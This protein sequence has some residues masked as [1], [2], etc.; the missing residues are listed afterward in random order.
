MILERR[1]QSDDPGGNG[2]GGLGETM[3]CADLAA[4]ECIEAPSGL[5]EQSLVSEALKV[6]ARDSCCFEITR[7]SNPTV[8]SDGE[9]EFPEVFGLDRGRQVHLSGWYHETPRICNKCCRI[10]GHYKSVV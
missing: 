3:V 7:T 5:R 6:D 10:G 8:A 4:R 1:Q 9:N 2:F